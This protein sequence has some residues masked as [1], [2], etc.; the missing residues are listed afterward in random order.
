MLFAQL[1]RTLVFHKDEINVLLEKSE[2]ICEKFNNLIEKYSNKEIVLYHTD[3]NH[4]NELVEFL[5]KIHEKYLLLPNESKYPKE[6]FHYYKTSFNKG[7][8]DSILY[9]ERDI[10]TY[11]INNFYLT[12][13]STLSYSK[14]HKMSNELSL[15]RFIVFIENIIIMISTAIGYSL[16]KSLQNIN[17]SN[18]L[19]NRSYED[20]FYKMN[21]SFEE[22]INMGV[23]NISDLTNFVIFGKYFEISRINAEILQILEYYNL[24]NKTIIVKNEEEILRE[25]LNN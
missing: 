23:N 11:F 7:L 4:K 6:T 18:E 9:I 21:E 25:I 14:S 5:N 15:S 2:D 1:L 24:K 16:N 8:D 10:L 19:Y 13:Q 20:Y 22:S 3:I 17:K 12:N